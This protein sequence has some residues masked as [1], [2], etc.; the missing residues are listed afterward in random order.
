MSFTTTEYSYL[1]FHQSPIRAFIC[2]HN[3]H[4][5]TANQS[6]KH[7]YMLQI[8]MI[9][10]NSRIAILQ[11]HQCVCTTA[12]PRW[13]RAPSWMTDQHAPSYYTVL[14]RSWAFKDGRKIWYSGL[15]VKISGL[16]RGGQSTSLLHQPV[17]HI[18]GSG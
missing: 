13:K 2:S 5:A 8:Q 15:S 18:S 17:N 9:Q 6:R 14:L 16:C 7:Q 1:L 11:F 3:N 12:T 10:N 4:H